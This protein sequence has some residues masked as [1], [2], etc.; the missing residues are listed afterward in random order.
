MLFP[1]L[2]L[3]REKSPISCHSTYT[4]ICSKSVCI[5]C[6]LPLALYTAKN[7]TNEMENYTSFFQWTNRDK[8]ITTVPRIDI[9]QTI[10]FRIY[11]HLFSHGVYSSVLSWGDTAIYSF[12]SSSPFWILSQPQH[13]VLEYVALMEGKQ[14]HRTH[15]KTVR[16]CVTSTRYYLPHVNA[17]NKSMKKRQ[18]GDERRKGELHTMSV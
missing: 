13:A 8:K 3:F 18:T 14:E 7:V 17:V 2:L 1:W 10:F 15:Y 9:G 16:S 6:T 4:T 5:S 12:Y 11:L